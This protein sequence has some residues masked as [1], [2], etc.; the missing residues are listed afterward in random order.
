[1]PIIQRTSRCGIILRGFFIFCSL[2]I[3]LSCA[4]VS[5]VNLARE[6]PGVFLNIEDV[7]SDFA[8]QPRWQVFAESIGYFH[9]KIASPRLEFWALQI[10]LRA[11]DTRVVVRGGSADEGGTLSTKVSS[12]VRDNNLAAGINAVPFN[13]ASSVENQPI[14]NIGIVISGGRLVSAAVPQYDA[15]V[16]YDDGR[17]AVVS[18]STINSTEGIE[19]AIGGFHQIL[20]I[21]QPLPKE[22]SDE[23]RHPRSAAG[24]SADGQ[25]LY[26]LVID[27]RRPGSAGATERETAII[28]LALGARS[29]I[30][31]DGG[32]SSALALRYPDGRIK[33]VNTPIHAGIPG[34][35]RAVAGCIGV[36]LNPSTGK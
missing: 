25:Y 14:Q 4:T 2:Q 18:Q 5:P 24:I 1:M 26:L 28:L 36:A 13:I 23:A 30:N 3:L 21:G 6:R 9:G 31:F 35:E 11:P 33:P 17:A 12:F 34:L 16:F 22:A 27:G 29:G 8:G 7:L 19:N 32:G 20:A 15:L 10:D